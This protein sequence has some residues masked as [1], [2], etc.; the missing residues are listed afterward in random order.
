MK[1]INVVWKLV[2][3]LRVMCP[4]LIKNH[5]ITFHSSHLNLLKHNPTCCNV[6]NRHL[7]S[8]SSW[9]HNP[10][11][12]RFS[13]IILNFDII[14]IIFLNFHRFISIPRPL[15]Y[16]AYII[17]TEIRNWKVIEKHVV[18]ASV[19]T[20]LGVACR[21]RPMTGRTVQ[22]RALKICPCHHGPP[23]WFGR[24]GCCPLGW[25]RRIAALGLRSMPSSRWWRY[26]R[27]RGC[28]SSTRLL[29]FSF[30]FLPLSLSLSLSLS[31][32]L[33]HKSYS[34]R[35]FPRSFFFFHLPSCIVTGQARG[36]GS[37][38]GTEQSG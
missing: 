15:V 17:L 6:N 28:R 7:S 2:T 16:F 3:L 33:S 13:F 9:T 32:Y 1:S 23:N 24:K 35:S 31:Q 26:V 4:R 14:S 12:S 36:A 27:V 38:K 29:P 25:Q 22:E 20:V 5:V 10:K 30:S 21:H 19:A 18:F 37:F 8:I 11:H 34:S